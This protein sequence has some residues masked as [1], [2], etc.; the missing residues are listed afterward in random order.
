MVE[1]AKDDKVN[2]FNQVFAL[3]MPTIGNYLL[4]VACSLKDQNKG[5]IVGLETLKYLSIQYSGTNS[6]GGSH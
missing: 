4:R 2:S 6:H 1:N 3:S 5:H